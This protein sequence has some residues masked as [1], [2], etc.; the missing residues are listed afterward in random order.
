MS[1]LPTWPIAAG[2]LVIGVAVGA[3]ADRLWMAPKVVAAEAKYTR[4]MSQNQE[5]ARAT[6]V[7][8]GDDERAAREKEQAQAKAVAQIEQRKIDEIATINARHSAAI[9]SLQQRP[10]RKPASPSG[11]P[12][13]SATCQGATGA[14][15]SRPD[16]GFLAGEA[17]RGDELRAALGACYQAYDSVAR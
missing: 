17:A 3:G 2:C 13:P 16:A 7:K 12:V 11:V 5:A 14:E 8:R 9:A 4:L 10:D 6:Q 1:I 15:L